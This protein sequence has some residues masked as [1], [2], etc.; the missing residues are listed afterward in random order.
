MP[1]GRSTWSFHLYSCY[2]VSEKGKIS[3]SDFYS[4]CVLKFLKKQ[5]AVL[6]KGKIVFL[7][8]KVGVRLNIPTQSYSVGSPGY[9]QA[10]FVPLF[11]CFFLVTPPLYLQLVVRHH[12]LCWYETGNYSQPCQVSFIRHCRGLVSA[13]EEQSLIKRERGRSI[14]LI[15][16]PLQQQ[17]LIR[18]PTLIWLLTLYLLHQYELFLHLLCLLRNR[19]GLLACSDS[20]SPDEQG[21]LKPCRWGRKAEV[22]GRVQLNK[23]VD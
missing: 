4:L 19:V 2:N 23:Q 8:R 3:K 12:F 16:C 13:K 22:G 11:I 5:E 10:L 1:R 7:T 17:T 14:L 21:V 9:F 20:P 15:I 6:H 18:S